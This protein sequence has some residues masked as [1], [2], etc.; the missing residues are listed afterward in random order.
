MSATNTA[1][2]PVIGLTVTTNGL[3]SWTPDETN[4]PSTNIVTIS[5]TDTNVAALVNRSISVTNSFIIVVREVNT[6]PQFI[7]T[8]ASQTIA[9][10]TALVVT[11]AATD[12]DIPT[13][14]LVYRLLNP[15]AGA[16]IDTNNGVITWTPSPA[17]AGTTNTFTTVVRDNGVPPLNA[18]NVFTVIVTALNTNPPSIFSIIHTNLGGTNGFLITWFAPTNQLFKVQWEDTLAPSSWQ[19]FSNLVGYDLFISPTNSR[20]TF[21]DDGSQT[22]GFGPTRFYRLVL[23]GLGAAAANTPPVLPPQPT[24]FVTPLSPLT[25]TNQA[26]DADLPAQ[27]LTYA[28]THNVAGLNVPVLNTNTGVITWTPTL[29]QAGTTNTLTTTVTDNGTPNLSATNSFLVIVNPIPAFSSAIVSTNGVNLLWF[30]STNE[31]FRVQWA[32]NLMTPIAWTL[33]P[34]IITSTN[35]TFTFTDT[36]APLLLKFYELLLLP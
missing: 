30:G 36:N 32:T 19:S 15:P 3:I 35:G 27:T 1:G 7:L 31:Q 14:T 21:F 9:P 25:V 26:T 4:G 20:F 24:R 17:Q 6:A 11:N 16:A 34:G 18:T 2:L 29:A 22:G 5:V 8:P 28:F 12:S 33:F 23:F 13:N 10:L